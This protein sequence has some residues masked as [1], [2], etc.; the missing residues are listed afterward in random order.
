VSWLGITRFEIVLLIV[1]LVGTG[2]LAWAWRG[3]ATGGF[4]VLVAGA[5]TVVWAIWLGWRPALVRRQQRQAE[6]GLG[7]P[8]DRSEFIEAV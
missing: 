4:V 3:G 2:V 8:N 6:T 5:A 1:F 7:T